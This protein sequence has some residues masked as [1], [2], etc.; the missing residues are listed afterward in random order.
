MPPERADGVADAEGMKEGYRITCVLYQGGGSA[1]LEKL[2]LK[3]FLMASLFYA[4]GKMIGEPISSKRNFAFQ[5]PKEVVV[6]LCLKEDYEELFQ[7][8]W[9]EQRIS[10]AGQGFLY[11]AFV[12]YMSDFQLPE[13]IS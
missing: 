5:M 1:L 9:Q 13:G 2:R 6:V 3:G 4:R 7:W 11:S 12:S 8:I 10:E